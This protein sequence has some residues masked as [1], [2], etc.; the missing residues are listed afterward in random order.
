MAYENLERDLPAYLEY[1]SDIL[2]NVNYRLMSLA[3][4]GLWDTMRK[5]CWVNHFVPSHASDMAKILHIPEVEIH[6]NLTNRVL[7][8]FCFYEGIFI[9]L[10]LISIEKKH[11]IEEFCKLGGAQKVGLKHK[12]L[13]ERQ[14]LTLKVTLR[15]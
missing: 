8:F 11:S 7:S 14:K 9:A 13:S 3:E 15:F 1:A 10:N 4:R 2:S 5:E 6:E 12:I